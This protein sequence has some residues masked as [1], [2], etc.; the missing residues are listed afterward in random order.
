MRDQQSSSEW[1][2][3]TGECIVGPH[4]GRSLEMLATTAMTWRAFR[5]TFPDASAVPLAREWWR[6]LL[7]SVFGRRGGG[8]YLPRLFRAT[9]NG[10]DPRLPEG[11][12]GLGVF[13]GARSLVG[14]A[15]VSAAR[16]YPFRAV[17]QAGLIVDDLDDTPIVVHYD[18]AVDTPIALIARLDGRRIELARAGEGTLRDRATGSLFDPI[19]RAKSGELAGQRL[20]LA[21]SVWTRWYGFSQTYPE[22]DIWSA[23]D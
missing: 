16:F 3:Y 8:G 11:E 5:A 17:K 20:A 13:L 10:A 18:A 4:A 12:L 23:P 6:R 9:M 7:G 2:H 19:G 1:L 21:P 14:G 22:T 15:R